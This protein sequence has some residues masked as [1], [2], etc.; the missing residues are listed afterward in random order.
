MHS[1]SKDEESPG[2]PDQEAVYDVLKQVYDPEVGI[3]IVDMAS[4]TAWRSTIKRSI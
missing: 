3:N 4:F 2:M 1:T